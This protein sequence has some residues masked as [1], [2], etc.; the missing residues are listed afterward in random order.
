MSEFSPTNTIMNET[1]SWDEYQ[2]KVISAGRKK[3]LLIEAGPG[4]GKT[5]VACARVAWLIENADVNPGNIWIISFTKTAVSEIR[6]RIS[7]FLSEKDD[8]YCVKIATLDSHAW[9]VHSGFKEGAK[10]VGSFEH[11]IEE[12]IRLIQNDSA[13]REYLLEVEH[14]VVDEAQDIVGNR[15]KLVTEILKNLHSTCG[16]SIFCDRAQAIYGFSSDTYFA[17]TNSL[18]SYLTD[19]MTHM[20]MN[21]ERTEL[22]EIH[23]T[24]EKNLCYIFSKVREKVLDIEVSNS[25]RAATVVSE[26]LK[27]SNGH[28]EKG[29]P[30]SFS[31]SD[32]AF[33]LF[34]RRAEVLTES[35][36]MGKKP[37]RIRMSGLPMAIKPWIGICLN[38]Y[39][40][41]LL[42]KKEFE[43]IWVNRREYLYEKETLNCSKAWNL[44]VKHA[45]LTEFSVEMKELRKVLSRTPPPLDFLCPEFGLSGPILGTIHASKGREAEEVDL[46]IPSRFMTPYCSIDAEEIRVLFVGAT[47]AKKNL[48]IGLGY[49]DYSKTLKTGRTYRPFVQN[50]CPRSRVEIGREGDLDAVGI[51]GKKHF[52]N[53]EDVRNNMSFFCDCS[54]TPC[55]LNAERGELERSYC[56]TKPKG[57]A[58]ICYLSDRITRD[59]GEILRE[60]KQ[61]TVYENLS[62][63]KRIKFLRIM[64]ARTIVLPPESEECKQILDPWSNSGILL[65]PLLIGYPAPWFP[66]REVNYN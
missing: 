43:I 48:R 42:S 23:R 22:K 55:I 50:S 25:T 57:K 41:K 66:H 63:P 18:K 62:L 53:P 36:M 40:E 58:S 24:Q 38:D 8:A 33:R 16:A 44:L 4:T 37:H 32:D 1:C 65:A 9:A 15:A 13:V 59:L 28:A 7:N 11:N 49:D 64:G 54:K 52:R 26:I 2:K 12:A 47:R 46:M 10:L 31:S 21:F 17:E 34:R 35:N 45:G 61:E 5:A 39:C 30:D 29:D 6:N 14:L 51:A 56:I 20:G 3:R 27:C 19:Y 60:L